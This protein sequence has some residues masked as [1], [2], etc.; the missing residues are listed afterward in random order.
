MARNTKLTPALQKRIC[1]GLKRGHYLKTAAPLAGVSARSAQSWLARGRKEEISLLMGKAAD[2]AEAIYVKF[3]HATEE[4][5]SHAVDR[6]LQTLESEISKNARAAQWYLSH[7]FSG[8]WSGNEELEERIEA[9]EEVIA[10]IEEENYGK[11]T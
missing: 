9:L 10:K 4:A 8:S 2:N 7:R 1:E 3:L 11:R 5:T 6:A